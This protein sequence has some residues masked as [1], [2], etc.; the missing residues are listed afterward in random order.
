MIQ[1]EIRLRISGLLADKEITHSELARR[2]GI[3]RQNVHAFMSGE[4][5][6]T[7]NVLAAMLSAITG[8]QRDLGRVIFKSF[9]LKDY[10]HQ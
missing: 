3:P 4:R 1:E 2:L 10:V 8:K 7:P 9:G 6:I 5:T